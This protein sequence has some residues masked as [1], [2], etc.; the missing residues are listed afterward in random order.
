MGNKIAISDWGKL[1]DRKPAYALVAN[2][3]LVIIRYN[4]NISVFYGRC[5]H[6]GALL[7]DGFIEGQNLICG[8]HNWDYRYDT[9]ISEY[10]NEEQLHKFNA[11]IDD[12]KVWID[13]D[14]VTNQS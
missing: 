5:H 14:E 4:D 7:A 1:E 11:T 3:D 8:V 9:G 2:T 6:R 12:G 13:E 10:K